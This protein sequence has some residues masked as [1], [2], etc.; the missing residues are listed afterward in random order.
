MAAEVAGRVDKWLGVVLVLLW[1]VCV[2]LS[3]GEF[4]L[5][6]KSDEVHKLFGLNSELYYVR[7]GQVNDYAL[8]FEVV[9]QANIS[10]LHFTWQSLGNSQ[11]S[12]VIAIEVNSTEA[13]GTPQ[14]NITRTGII[15]NEEQVFR[16]FLP[17]TGKKSEEVNINLHMNITAGSRVNITS[18]ILKR[19][20]ICLKDPSAIIASASSFYVAIGCACALILVI[21]SA[22]T[23]CYI[24]A[25]KSCQ[26]EI[27]NYRGKSEDLASQ[28]QTFLRVDT[29][30]NASITGSYGSYR[31]LTPIALA[32][33]VNDLRASELTEKIS[34]IVVERR[35]ISLHEKLQEG[36]FGQIYHGMFIE[37][38]NDVSDVQ[39]VFVKTVS[40][41][42]S[43]VQ[44]S[45]LL[46]EGMKMFSFI[47]KNVLP[48]IGVCMD[49]PQRPLLIYPYMNQGNLKRF[50]HKC[51]FSAEGHCHTLVTQDLVAMAI[52]IVQGIMY[53]HKKKVIHGDIAGRNCVH[54]SYCI[55][56]LSL[57]AAYFF[58]Q[59]SPPQLV[60]LPLMKSLGLNPVFV[61]LMMMQLEDGDLLY[62]GLWSFG[63][64]LWE[65]MTLGQQ[66]YVE[67]DP[68]EMLASLRDGYRLSQPVNC[69]DKLYKL[70]A[71]CWTA[72]PEERPTFGQLLGYLQDFYTA[73]G[74]Y[75]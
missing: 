2:E 13:L 48:V 5:F 44:I 11:L 37:D 55:Y 36:T 28:G 35:K 31:R 17:C 29:P 46:G 33:H 34:E 67:I 58:E 40:D 23:T 50:L 1:V 26:N 4:S 66:P 15:P 74:C 32:V 30:N 54:G 20:K 6:L 41:Q 42:A 16:L 70:M 64:T 68:F 52:Q 63:V 59:G 21:T 14:L 19:K 65:L 12:Y 18:L 49:N 10:E 60:H 9:V 73:L 45:L 62:H 57:Q 39:D 75:I 61:H 27:I 7:K 3:T 56:Q 8:K 22:A 25:R 72:V 24:R 51:Q 47:H 43:Q 71:F 53:L 69:P 38:E